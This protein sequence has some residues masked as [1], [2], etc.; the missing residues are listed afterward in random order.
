MFQLFMGISEHDVRK[1][2]RKNHLTKNHAK[3]SSILAVTTKSI[4]IADT[5][6]SF[7]SLNYF[8]FVSLSLLKQLITA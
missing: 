1:S 2:A 8:C 5:F 3:T 6:L 4:P 7:N